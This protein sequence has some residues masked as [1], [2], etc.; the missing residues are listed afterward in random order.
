MTLKTALDQYIAWRQAQG[1]DGRSTASILLAYCRSVGAETGCD[2]VSSAQASAFLSGRPGTNTRACKHSTLAAF[3][4][5]AL[6]RGLATSSP[7]PTE[8]PKRHPSA[9][10][11]IYS[12]DELR[13]LLDATRTYRKR[14]CQLQPQVF[15]VLLLLL[16]GTGLR[17]GEALQLTLSDID[18]PHRLLT[19]RHA[20]F[21]RTRLVPLGS[22]LTRILQTHAAG[23]PTSGAPPSTTPF[24]ANRDGT[25]LVHGTVNTAFQKLR[26]AAGV[27]AP[28]GA[29]QQPRLHDVRHT[30]AVHRLIA[31][32]RQGADLQRM[33]P[34]LS[35]YLGHSSLDGTRV[36][37]S[38][39]PEL[40]HEAALRFERYAAT[41]QGGAH[42]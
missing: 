3:Y 27:C 14:V 31:W 37:L 16:Y 33:L 32:Y 12:H 35:V 21:S 39:T 25:P 9:P 10:P 42:D 28:E 26:C 5:Y 20:K 8:P 22:Q 6:A 41:A 36:Y 18:L 4:R 24:L 23:L 29:R 2:E 17:P 7:L 11:H 1:A 38:M 15:R 19:V 40:L 13:R 30:F 34:L